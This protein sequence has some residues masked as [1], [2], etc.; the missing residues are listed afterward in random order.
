MSRIPLMALALI[1][2]LASYAVASASFEAAPAERGES[3]VV[4]ISE[5]MV[6]AAEQ[7]L[8]VNNAFL[9]LAGKMV[10]ESGSPDADIYL[11]KAYA[12]AKEGLM[13]MEGGDFEFAVEDF[14]ESTRMAV[15]AVVLSGGDDD[16]LKEAVKGQERLHLEE[17]EHERKEKLIIKGFSEA[18]TFINTAERLLSESYHQDA[19]RKVDEAKELYRSAKHA[20]SRGDYDM[21]LSDIDKAY[22]LSTD[23]IRDIKSSE[24]D[25]ITF[26]RPSF[27]DDRAIYLHE[28]KRNETYMFLA[29]NIAVDGE[30]ARM[31]KEAGVLVF[32]SNATAAFFCC[33]LFE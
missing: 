13:H 23:S 10:K 28:L 5:E 31:L 15:Y 12:L 29:E 14:M 1:L 4:N 32:P 11:N 21:A 17:A 6:L 27:T 26:P 8:R 2:S 25:I 3:P 7:T 9:E 22:K 33:E 19:R 16:R 24:G 18:E 30:S 20:V